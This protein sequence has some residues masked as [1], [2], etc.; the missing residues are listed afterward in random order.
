ME[1]LSISSYDS[2][3]SSMYSDHRECQR[4]QQGMDWPAIRKGKALPVDLFSSEGSD[5]L[6]EEWLP[7]F[8]RMTL[9]ND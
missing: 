7:S 5:L 4:S 6:F 9:W 2:D 8:E 1:E 3:E